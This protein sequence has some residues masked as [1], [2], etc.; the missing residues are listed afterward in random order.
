MDDALL[1]SLR[2]LFKLEKNYPEVLTSSLLMAEIV[3]C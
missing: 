2:M 3:L 1:L